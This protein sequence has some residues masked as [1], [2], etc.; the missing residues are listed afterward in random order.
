MIMVNFY[1]FGIFSSSYK[2][3]KWLFPHIT[4]N[5]KGLMHMALNFLPITYRA[6]SLN[7]F[8]TSWNLTKQPCVCFVRDQM[9]CEEKSV[10]DISAL[11]FGKIHLAGY[12]RRQRWL[13]HAFPAIIRKIWMLGTCL[14]HSAKSKQ[15]SIL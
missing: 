8:K 4:A 15:P 14:Y 7:E 2:S 13:F 11:I 9:Y 12:R 3:Q 1:Q 5:F 10:L 6:C